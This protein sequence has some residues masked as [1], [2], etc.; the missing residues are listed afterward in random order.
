MIY[1]QSFINALEDIIKS[2]PSN[3]T[4]IPNEEVI[5]MVSTSYNML[6]KYMHSCSTK[7]FIFYFRDC[8]LNLEQVYKIA[9]KSNFP[10]PYISIYE[11]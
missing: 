11:F 3:I 10:I 6:V 5:T 8:E 2:I 9:E 1:N 4:N 7:Y